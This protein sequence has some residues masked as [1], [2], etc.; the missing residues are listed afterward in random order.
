[1]LRN[2]SVQLQYQGCSFT[3]AGVT[4]EWASYIPNTLKTFRHATVDGLRILVAHQ[5]GQ[6]DLYEQ[7]VRFDWQLQGIQ[8]HSKRPHKDARPLSTY[9]DKVRIRRSDEHQPSMSNYV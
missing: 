6:K 9:A 1:M 3:L 7:A 8:P 2:D 4:D 5:H